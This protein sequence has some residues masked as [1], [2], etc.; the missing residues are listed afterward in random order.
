MKAKESAANS[1]VE[2][3]KMSAARE[4]TRRDVERDALEARVAELEARVIKAERERAAAAN[5]R[6][7]A[8]VT[9]KVQ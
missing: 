4:E 5:A 6:D 9:D 2:E 1:A 3:L 7:K 8:N